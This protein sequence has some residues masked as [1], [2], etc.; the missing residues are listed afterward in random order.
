MA[1][2]SFFVLD[3]SGLLKLLLGVYTNGLHAPVFFFLSV[4]ASVGAFSSCVYQTIVGGGRVC[5]G[6]SKLEVT[7]PRDSSSSAGV[8]DVVRLLLLL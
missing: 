6:S 5:L 3:G 2:L 8:D 1:G 7:F 4:E